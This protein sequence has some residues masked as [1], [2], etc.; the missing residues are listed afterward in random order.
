MK[1]PFQLSTLL[2]SVSLDFLTSRRPLILF[3]FGFKLAEALLVIPLVAAGLAIVLMMAGHIA[4][5]N[6]DILTFLLTPMGLL[7]AAIVSII[8]VGLLLFEQAGYMSFAAL[9]DSVSLPKLTQYLA[10]GV[11]KPWQVFKLGMV[12]LLFGCLAM[13]PFILAAVLVYKLLLSEHD[14]N[15]YLAER[16]PVFWMA[17]SS[18]MVILI[19]SLLVSAFLFT[20]WSLALPIVLFE[21]QRTFAALQASRDRVQGVRWRI[22]SILLGWIV[23]AILFGIVLEI[24]FSYFAAYMLANAGERP[25]VRIMLLLIAQAGL[26]ATWTFIIIVVVAL[27]TWRLYKMRN[28]ELGLTEHDA[29]EL[30]DDVKMPKPFNWKLALVSLVL[31]LLSPLAIWISLARFSA[32]RLPLEV[33]AHRGHAR[34]APEN[35][36][37]AVR[38]AI[39]SGADYAEIDVLQTSDGVVILMHDRDLKRVSG[40]TRRVSDLTFEQMRKLDVGSWFGPAFK[41]ERVP[42]LQ[43]VFDLARGKITASGTTGRGRPVKPA[44]LRKKGKK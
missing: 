15:F 41:G 13:A 30:V 37:S 16:P 34:A 7:Y 33:T 8:S 22:G 23:G 28:A 38:K 29:Q 18:G 36:L 26:L 40:D 4:V 35:T 2:K 10:A 31:V 42:T 5:S 12:E 24:G 1:Q 17:V 11:R 39:E 19:A 21:D 27:L 43:E 25:F 9:A 3:S 32:E 20:R 14:I 6:M 44:H